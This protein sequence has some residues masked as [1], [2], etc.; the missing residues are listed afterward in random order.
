MDRYDNVIRNESFG[1]DMEGAEHG[2]GVDQHG[3][4]WLGQD[5]HQESDELSLANEAGLWAATV[6]HGHEFGPTM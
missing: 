4:G 6:H 2:R 5:R 3:W 1:L